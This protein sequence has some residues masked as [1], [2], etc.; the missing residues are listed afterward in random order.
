MIR[1]VLDTNV[2]V[3]GIF[4]KGTPF[5]IL[6]AWQGRRFHLVISR[7]ILHEY[8]RVLEEMT[9]KRPSAVIGSILEVIQLHSEMIEPVAFAKTVC[10]DPDDDKF[11][12]AAVAADAGYIVSGDS[13][14]LKLKNYSGVE[15]VRPARFVNLLH[16]SPQE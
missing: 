11:L 8:T 14:L 9:K 3:S 13:A 7:P 2:L 10:S 16:P 1:A 12:E 5:E 4:W 6:Q 15:I